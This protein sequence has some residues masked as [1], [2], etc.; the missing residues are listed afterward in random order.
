MCG[1]VEVATNARRSCA[2]H[3]PT[4]PAPVPVARFGCEIDQDVGNHVLVGEFK[5]PSERYEEILTGLAAEGVITSELRAGLSGLGGLRN[6]LVHGYM[7]VDLERVL[8]ILDDAPERF[9]RFAH[10]LHDWLARRAGSP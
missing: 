3:P 7:D 6:L 9:E 2:P 4:R 1:T 8:S 10:E 5:R